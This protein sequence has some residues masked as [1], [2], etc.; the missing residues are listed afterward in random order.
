MPSHLLVNWSTSDMYT[1]VHTLY[2]FIS[3]KANIKKEDIRSRYKTCARRGHVF[4]SHLGLHPALVPQEE[5]SLYP[6]LAWVLQ[7]PK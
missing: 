6:T 5:V 1:S 4:N 3:S 2:I 7:N